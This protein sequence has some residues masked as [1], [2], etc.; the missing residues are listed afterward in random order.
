MIE[1]GSPQVFEVA[2][3]FKCGRSHDE[4]SRKLIVHNRNNRR[5]RSGF[6]RELA[7]LYEDDAV[8]AVNKPSGLLAVPVVS[9]AP[10][11]LSILIDEF[12]KKRERVLVVHRI[13]RFASGVLLFA[14]TQTDREA[15]I[16][17]FLQHTPLR[18]YVTVVRGQLTPKEATLVHYFRREGMFQKLSSERD[19]KAGLCA[20]FSA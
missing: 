4:V 19:S 10:S 11:A 15:L 5:R 3:G 6:S 2:R 18:E 14:K 16:R 8:V 1:D 13:D 12:K 9:D 7:V 17:E 20:E